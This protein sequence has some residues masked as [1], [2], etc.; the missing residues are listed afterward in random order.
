MKN[1]M[2]CFVVGFFLIQSFGVFA[3]TTEITPPKVSPNVEKVL[4]T[5][6]E[7]LTSSATVGDAATKILP[8]AGGHLIAQSGNAIADDVIQFSLKKDHQNAHFYQSPAKITRVQK[9]ENDYD[10]YG[11]TLIEGT[12]FKI[13]VAK[14]EGVAG[15]PAPV[16]IIVPKN[17]PSH[18]KVISNIGSL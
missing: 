4:N 6:L 7:A 12:T 11:V 17:D 9:I 2:I 18:P 16:R 14:K 3:Q 15:M 13:W 1:F 5:Y 10:G 8:I